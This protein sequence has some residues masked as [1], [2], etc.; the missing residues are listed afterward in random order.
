VDGY[1]L[2]HAWPGIAP[3]RPRHSARAREELVHW[4]TQYQ[5]AVRTP[6]TV[7]FDGI[8][9]PADTPKAHSRPEM[10]IIFSRSGRT[11]DDLI[12]RTTH[13]LLPYGDVLVVTD[14]NAERDTVLSLGG[15]AYSCDTFIADFNSVLG[16][17][18]LDLHHINRRERGQ[19]KRP[20]SR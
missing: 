18:E 9:A 14:D 6:I 10:E 1:S 15:L 4:L 8:R 5:D 13:R 19:F 7:F 2:L 16:E 12:E 11:A 17:L 20:H 3:G